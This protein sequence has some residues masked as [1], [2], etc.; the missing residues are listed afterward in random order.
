M[1]FQYKHPTSSLHKCTDNSHQILHQQLRE[2]L[3]HV[4]LPLAQCSEWLVAWHG[5]EAE[6]EVLDE[7]VHAAVPIAI[8][9]RVPAGFL[10][11]PVPQNKGS[12]IWSPSI[13]KLKKKLVFTKGDTH[14][15]RILT[16]D[17]TQAIWDPSRRKNQGSLRLHF[18]TNT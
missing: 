16:R 18:W 12:V 14:T 5:V 17:T 9:F 4:T 7:P 2:F 13:Q 3:M 15:N 10:L 11:F 8:V 6:A 1:T